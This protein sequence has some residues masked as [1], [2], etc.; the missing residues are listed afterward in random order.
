[1]K[2]ETEKGIDTAVKFLSFRS[3]TEKEVVDHLWKKKYGETIIIEII[4]RLKEYR[5]IDDQAYLKNYLASNF[6]MN[7]YGKIRI[8]HDLKRKGLS[9]SVLDRLDDY[10]SRDLEKKFCGELVAKYQSQFQGKTIPE[11]KKKL[12]NKLLRLGYEGTMVLDCLDELSWEE[13]NEKKD[14]VKE[15]LKL[16][17]DYEKYKQR[18]QK[19]GYQDY[20]LE[21]RI[22]RNLA[23]R[24]YS[25][26]DIKEMMDEKKAHFEE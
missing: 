17:A 12:Y 11:R 16:A 1:M 18:H 2:T 5:Y 26:E 8:R 13:N 10:Y 22:F 6:Q 19:K 7:P 9:E 4:N 23:G 25:F 24:G 3:R 21:Q 15:R 20:E 14:Q